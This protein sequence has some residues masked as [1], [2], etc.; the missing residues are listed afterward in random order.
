[1]SEPAKMAEKIQQRKRVKRNNAC[2]L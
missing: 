1:M 2:V